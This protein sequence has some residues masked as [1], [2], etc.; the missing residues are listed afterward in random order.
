M[1]EEKI[2]P[3]PD[4]EKQ[5]LMFRAVFMEQASK[6]SLNEAKQKV[7]TAIGAWLTV[8]VFTSIVAAVPALFL[9]YRLAFTR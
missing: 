3:T 2:D 6:S 9:L 8:I 5:E 7:L 4:S 1:S